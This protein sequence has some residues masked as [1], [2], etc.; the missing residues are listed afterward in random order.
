MGLQGTNFKIQVG[1]L[2]PKEESAGLKAG[3]VRVPAKDEGKR[4]L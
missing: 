2:R 4:P 3:A 1:S